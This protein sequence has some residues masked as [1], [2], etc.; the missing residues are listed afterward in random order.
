MC[1]IHQW[2]FCDTS[3][4][5]YDNGNIG[6]RI[7]QWSSLIIIGDCLGWSLSNV[8]KASE[9]DVQSFPSTFTSYIYYLKFAITVIITTIIFVIFLTAFDA[10]N[11]NYK[12]INCQ[13]ENMLMHIFFVFYL[14]LCLIHVFVKTKCLGRRR[15]GTMVAWPGSLQIDLPMKHRP[16][17]LTKLF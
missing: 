3:V 16:S 6:I 9:I 12:F 7:D 13:Q 1:T 10:I 5:Y 14:G 4:M 17:S 11:V 8:N 15:I 2:C